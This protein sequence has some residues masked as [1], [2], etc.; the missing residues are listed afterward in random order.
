MGT[1]DTLLAFL[2]LITLLS[3]QLFL[4]DA[5]EI[6]V[7]LEVLPDLLRYVCIVED[8]AFH[9]YFRANGDGREGYLMYGH[10]GLV[11]AQYHGRVLPLQIGGPNERYRK[12]DGGTGQHQPVE[13][14]N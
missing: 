12:V 1:Q 3:T 11:K 7:L 6:A 5:G 13:S 14:E 10:Q 4:I 9:F 8:V 2:T